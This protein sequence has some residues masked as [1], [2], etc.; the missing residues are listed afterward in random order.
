ME[1]KPRSN[2]DVTTITIPNGKKLKKLALF[3]SKHGDVSDASIKIE[4][5]RVDINGHKIT[6]RNCYCIACLNELLMNFQKNGDIGNLA[7]V[8]VV[9]DEDKKEE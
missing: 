7:I 6:D 4:S 2:E 9:E 5:S 3:C 1:E 8:P